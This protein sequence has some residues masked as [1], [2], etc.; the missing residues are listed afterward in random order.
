MAS[1]GYCLG[2]TSPDSASETETLPGSW[3]SLGGEIWRVVA[4]LKKMLNGRQAQVDAH[5][6]LF[7]K[8]FRTDFRAQTAA[9]R[10]D[11]PTRFFARS[12][13][14]RQRSPPSPSYCAHLARRARKRSGHNRAQMNS[15]SSFVAKKCFA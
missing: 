13:H 6:S 2:S 10:P 11:H 8:N 7:A 14:P 3:P 4:A 12:R 15:M 9:A 5:N 1:I